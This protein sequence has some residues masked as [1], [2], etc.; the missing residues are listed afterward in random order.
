MN[1]K[2]LLAVVFPFELFY[3]NPTLLC[4]AEYCRRWRAVGA[5]SRLHRWT[6]HDHRP[7]RRL[8]DDVLD[9]Y[10]EAARCCEHGELAL[11]VSEA[12]VAQIRHERVRECVTEV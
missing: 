4:E 1:E 12:V 9:E 11:R 6:L 3:G 8:V 5:K 10:R 2:F 7:V